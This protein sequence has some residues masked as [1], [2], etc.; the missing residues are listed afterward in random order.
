MA[1]AKIHDTKPE[2]EQLAFTNDKHATEQMQDTIN[3]H[4][5]IG[6]EI[7]SGSFGTVYLVTSKV[8]GKT[9]AAKCIVTK[10]RHDRS[11]QLEH[12]YC[13]LMARANIGPT[14]PRQSLFCERNGLISTHWIVMDKYSTD[15]GL[16][17]EEN[18]TLDQ[19]VLQEI[20]QRLR[21]CYTR[22]ITLD[23][24]S[25]DVKPTNVLIRYNDRLATTEDLLELKL[26]DFSA[27][28]QLRMDDLVRRHWIGLLLYYCFSV[29][30]NQYYDVEYI[31]FR[32]EI[33]CLLSILMYQTDDFMTWLTDN[34][35]SVLFRL[36]RHYAY[37]QSKDIFE[38]NIDAECFS[39]LLIKNCL[40]LLR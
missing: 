13:Q 11:V 25:C 18:I 14:L 3:A 24:C 37:Y 26:C 4:Y 12:W 15:L 29:Y 7:S 17:F 10:R 32:H 8:N 36:I 30:T 21:K 35:S 40:I 9:Y 2:D 16:V 23:F 19:L 39:K 34:Q 6:A 31:F 20:E 1:D 22:M 28:F 33:K 27:D 5:N 38:D